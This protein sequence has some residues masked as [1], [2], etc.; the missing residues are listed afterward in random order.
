MITTRKRFVLTGLAACVAMQAHGL[1]FDNT[2]GQPVFLAKSD[3]PPGFEELSKPQRS[4]VD[5]YYG[6]RYLGSQLAT[7][8]PQ[9]IRLSDP[10]LIIRQ[11]GDVSDRVLVTEGLTGKIEANSDQVCYQPGQSDCGIMEPPIAGVI[12]DESR[13][14]VDVFVN[15]RFLLTREA[16]VSKYLPASD[17]KDLSFMQNFSAAFSGTR[18]DVDNADNDDYSIYGN[19]M[20]AKGETSLRSNWDYSRNQHFSMSSFYGQRE[21]EGVSYRAGMVSSE[22]FGL[23]FTSD[24][25]LAGVRLGSS[26]NTRTDTNFSGGMP[27]DV[28]LTTRGRVEVRKDNRLIASYFLEA[29]SQQLDTSA[30]PSGA[31]DIE[32]KTFDEQGNPQNTEIR[33]FAKQFDLPPEGEWRYFLETGK[34]M[35]RSG[36]DVLPEMT[37]QVLARAGVSRRITETLAGTFS[38]AMNTRNTLGEMGL[39]HLGYRYEL[40]PSIMVGSGGAYGFNVIGRYTFGDVAFNASHRQLWNDDYDVALVEEDL[41]AL[42]GE[43]F[44]QS[45]Y[46]VTTPVYTGNASYRFSENKTGDEKATRTHTVGYR[47]NL[48]RVADID[49][50]L[51]ASYSQSDDNKIAL[52]GLTFRL[53]D[54]HW[55][56]RVN[57]K[58]E[59]QWTDNNNTRNERTRLQ[60]TWDD[61]DIFDSTVRAGFGVEAGTGDELYDARLEI[62]NTWGRA[63]MAVNHVQGDND[64]TSYSASLRSSF[65]TNGKQI[66]LGGEQSAESALMVNVNGTDGDVFDVNI[67]GQ[68]Q[69]YAVVGRPSLVP[70][71][72]YE[73]Y[74]VSVSPAGEAMYDFDE[75]E[76]SITLYPG[77]VVSLDYDAVALQLLFGRLMMHGQPLTFAKITGGLYPAD[78]DDVGLFQLELRADKK[79]ID[80]E[81][82]NGQVCSLPVPDTQEGNILRM[83]TI[84]M[85]GQYC[86][87]PAPEMDIADDQGEM[88]LASTAG[89]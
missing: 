16:N 67:N 52:L 54:D 8:T 9:T 68:R 20:V 83:G 38:A 46:S 66:A 47:T 42:L 85:S 64:T 79:V 35:S 75:R 10:A 4:L 1:P 26:D 82:Q 58:A 37:D 28:F 7:F 88:K 2:T 74:T 60:A 6:G 61:N 14:R 30:F 18:S 39:F 49:I 31:Y 48:Y 34:V 15:R 43:S 45:S 71:P 33:F 84:E 53:R 76:R 19:T 11:I 86:A 24:Q 51:D 57:P 32:I 3:V 78:S 63:D 12:F 87:A 81:L 23:S 50:D 55:S 72:P 25:I 62:G 40:T 56:Y 5:I 36:D 80:V 73:Q 77:N 59:R 22:G 29:G 17:A 13:F 65:M 70:L 44:R 41:P 69:G 89:G 27:L 21:F